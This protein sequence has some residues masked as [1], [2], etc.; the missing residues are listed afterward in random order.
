MQIHNGH[1]TL[2][3]AALIQ[4]ATQHE[5]TEQ[6]EEKNAKGEEPGE[7]SGKVV[8]AT[9]PD[10]PRSRLGQQR[11]PHR[12]SMVAAQ[13][14]LLEPAAVIR[15]YQIRMYNLWHDSND[16]WLRRPVSNAIFSCKL[17]PMML[18]QL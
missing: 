17:D 18:H 13:G 15:I 16:L 1:Q 4:R 2:T 9:S 10:T 3:S 14:R 12:A 6:G 8:A 11:A 5:E 7:V